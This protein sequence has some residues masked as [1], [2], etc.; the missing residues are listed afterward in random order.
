MTIPFHKNLVGACLLALLCGALHAQSTRALYQD[1]FNPVPLR[2]IDSSPS[3]YQ[4]GARESAERRKDSVNLYTGIRLLQKEEPQKAL[5]YL[6]RAAGNMKHIVSNVSEWYLALA[7]LRLG[8]TAQ[9]EYLFHKIAET[10]IHPHQDEAE[11]VYQQ[12]AGLRNKK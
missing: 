12:L 10:E 3:H 8:K 11:V 4:L 9:A 5:P 7:Y 6:Q 1:H 2:A